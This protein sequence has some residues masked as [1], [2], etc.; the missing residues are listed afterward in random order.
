MKIRFSSDKEQQ[1]TQDQGLKVLYAPGK[2]LAFKLRWYLILLAVLGPL[3][4]LA[5][6]W[7]L[8]LWLIQAPAQL[9]LPLLELR[10][11]EPGQVQQLLVRPGDPVEAG[12]VLVRLDNPEWR[13]RLALLEE[14]D[15]HPATDSPAR[16]S[17]R[18]REREALERLLASAEQRLGQL[19]GLQAAGAATRGE[20]QAASDLRDQRQR[21]LLQFDQQQAVVLP[22][23]A[24]DQQQRGLERRWLEER[25]EGLALQA[26]HAGEVSEILVNEGENIG[27]GNLLLRMRTDGEV[28]VWV[29]LEPRDVAYAVPGQPF[30]LRLP[31]G[32][33]LPA[34]VVR[35]VDDAVSVPGELR[36]AFSAPTRNLRVLARITGELP[37]RWR[38]DRLGLQAR[39]PHQWPWVDAWAGDE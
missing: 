22:Q 7:L 28:R 36:A 31:D 1:P 6:Q 11:R 24:F 32:R 38:A 29:Y 27:P 34:Q 23:V 39:F 10:A 13:A 19:R 26:P 25:L 37:K 15:Q 4:W 2:R 17:L 18:E 12:Q 14:P 3:L 30:R 16:R 21:D 5:G 20:V 9:E 33:W 8:S 35:A